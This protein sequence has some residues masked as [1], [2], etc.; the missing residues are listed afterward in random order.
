V[1]GSETDD[2]SPTIEN[3]CVSGQHGQCQLRVGGGHG[4]RQGLRCDNGIDV[5]IGNVID[6]LGTGDS[7]CMT[8]ILF[9]EMGWDDHSLCQC[10]FVFPFI[11]VQIGD[12][13]I[14]GHSENEEEQQHP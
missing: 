4:Q 6:G 14:F 13:F 11:N 12:S 2:M 9:L 3:D 10:W 8:V 7:I 1:A 5:G